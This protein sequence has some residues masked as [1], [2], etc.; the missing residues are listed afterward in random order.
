ML[1]VLMVLCKMTDYI[2]L[3]TP[4]FLPQGDQLCFDVVMCV[5]CSVLVTAS[6]NLNSLFL[7][8]VTMVVMD[9]RVIE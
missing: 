8:L 1:L 4:I 3:S 2:S 9:D 7:T 5:E 6:L